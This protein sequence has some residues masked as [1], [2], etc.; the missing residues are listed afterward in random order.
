MHTTRRT[1]PLLRSLIGTI[2]ITAFLNAQTAADKA[3]QQRITPAQAFGLLQEGNERF[4]TGKSMVHDHRAA[5]GATAKG[6]YPYAVVIGCIDSRTPAELL[7]DQGIGDLFN[8]RIAGN[9]VGPDVTGSVEFASAVAGARLIVVLGHTECGAV[10]GACD[11][12]RMGALTGVLDRIAP[13]V[14]SVADSLGEGSSKDRAFV[15]AVTEANIRNGIRQLRQS[16]IIDSLITRNAVGII[17]GTYDIARGTV[18]WL[19]DTKGGF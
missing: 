11:H 7:F 6:Q 12:V 19:D 14:R 1:A 15:Q 16:P 2:L 4:I 9:V 5:R 17:G 13:A 10:K 3:A 18:R 8:A